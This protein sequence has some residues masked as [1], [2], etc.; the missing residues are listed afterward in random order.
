MWRKAGE[1]A[2]PELYGGSKYGKQI[3]LNRAVGLWGGISDGGFSEVLFHS[4]K[5]VNTME[6]VCALKAG[7]LTSAIRSL[8]P[9]RPR[10]TWHVLC[11]TESFLT[12]KDALAEYH[13]SNVIL[14]HIPARSPDLNPVEKFWV[15]LRKQLLR[16]DLEDMVKHRPVLG[17]VAYRARVRAVCRSAKAMRV[18][19]NPAGGLRKVCKEVIKEGG[20]ATRG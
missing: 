19:K 18:A 3:P 13:R 1:S 5:K 16:R 2:S 10:S 8:G 12:A 11:D 14:W 9:V 6:W 20:A 15:W 17:K 7:V 4:T